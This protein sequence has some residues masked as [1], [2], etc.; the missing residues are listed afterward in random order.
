MNK[1]QPNIIYGTA[2]KKTQTK[3]LVEKAFSLGFTAIDTACQPKHYHEAGVGEAITA[4][5]QSKGR[6]ENLFI[7]TKFTP[8]Q[9]QDPQTVPYDPEAAL[10]KQ[11]AQ[12]FAVSK[13]NL[14]SDYVD[15]YLLHTPLFPFKDMLTAWRAM[16][17]IYERDE[18]K[19]LGISNIYD[20][21]WLKRLYEESNI[22]PAVVQNRFYKDT[23]YDTQLRHFCDQNGIR[24]QSF[25]TLTA[26]PHIL[27]S[28]EMFDQMRYYQKTP[29]QIFFAYLHRRDITPLTGTTQH[30]HMKMDLESMDL[31]LK[32]KTLLTIDKLLSC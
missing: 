24:Y 1:E 20:L 23:A 32:D 13:K 25:W 12:S 10:E 8:L 17:T 15:S 11:L 31:E 3:A 7:Q 18:A 16:E 5:C 27:Q 26:N 30:E 21:A 14:Q 4:Y 29:E 6:R 19:Q 9:G 22:K 28:R 2:W